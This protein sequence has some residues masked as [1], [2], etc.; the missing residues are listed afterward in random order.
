MLFKKGVTKTAE[1][2]NDLFLKLH[3][4]NFSFKTQVLFDQVNFLL[5]FFYHFVQL[6]YYS[7]QEGAFPAPTVTPP[8]LKVKPPIPAELTFLSDGLAACFTR[9]QQSTSASGDT[10]RPVHISHGTYSWGR[11]TWRLQVAPPVRGQTGQKLFSLLLVAP[12]GSA[13]CFVPSCT[14]DQVFPFILIFHRHVFL[15]RGKRG[16]SGFSLIFGVFDMAWFSAGF[17]RVFSWFSAGFYM[18]F[19]WF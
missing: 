13:M 6:G 14:Y 4:F 12:P 9:T 15:D 3:C 10:V 7:S 18:V 1:T 17:Q 16:L 8:P 2:T 5:F 19:S 11:N